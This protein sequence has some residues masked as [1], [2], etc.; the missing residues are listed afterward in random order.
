MAVSSDVPGHDT[1]PLE[2]RLRMKFGEK[3]GKSATETS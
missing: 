1:D 3:V 2:Q